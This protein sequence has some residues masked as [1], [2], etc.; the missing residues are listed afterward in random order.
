MQS[1]NANSP[2]PCRVADCPYQKPHVHVN[3]NNGSYVKYIIEK[4]KKY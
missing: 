3:T 1:R 4:P 2:E